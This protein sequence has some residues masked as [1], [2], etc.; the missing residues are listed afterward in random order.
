MSH[1]VMEINR[2]NGQQSYQ[3]AKSIDGRTH[4]VEEAQRY[5]SHPDA[6]AAASILEA[7]DSTGTFDYEVLETP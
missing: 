6:M 7:R 4:A 3:A 5:S 2:K 1:V